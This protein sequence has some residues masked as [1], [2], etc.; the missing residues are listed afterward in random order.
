MPLDPHTRLGPYEVLSLLG[1]GGMGEVYRGR[2]TRLGRAVAIKVVQT[3]FSA[4]FESEARAIA[5]LNHPNFQVREHSGAYGLLI[6]L[7]Q[8]RPF[9]GGNIQNIDH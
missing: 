8:T 4:R 6:Q 3:Q 1:E 2:D 7:R 5:A 9:G